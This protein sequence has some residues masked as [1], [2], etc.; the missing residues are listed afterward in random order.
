M[1]EVK[2]QVPA[3]VQGVRTLVDRS[4]K[5]DVITQELAPEEKTMLFE[6]QQKEG[7]FTFQLAEI[8]E[9]DLN[10]PEIKTEFKGDKS[11]GQRLRNTLYVY[12]EQQGAK[13]TFDDF[14]KK[15]VER[16]IS[17]IKEKLN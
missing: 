4:L 1:K 16:F 13:G 12:W 9:K 15:Q 5:L 2:F 3:V 17:A 14:Y 8:E 7:W 6:L 10:V 11:P